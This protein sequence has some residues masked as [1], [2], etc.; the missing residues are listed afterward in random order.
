MS[1]QTRFHRE[2]TNADGHFSCID[3]EIDGVFYH[4]PV[5]EMREADASKCLENFL[6][7]GRVAGKKY[8]CVVDASRM[9]RVLA[10]GRKIMGD[11]LVLNSDTPVVKMA[12]VLDSFLTRTMF[13]MFARIAKLPM[14]I[15]STREE[16][17][18]WLKG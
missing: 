8:L 3:E 15:F 13:S 6:E 10:E 14:K 11:A 5:G 2:V 12:V 1:N 7:Y 4:Q 9:D 16:A 18:Q 17:L